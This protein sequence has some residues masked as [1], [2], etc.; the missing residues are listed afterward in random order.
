MVE[1]VVNTACVTA[2]GSSLVAALERT[3]VTAEPF[4]KPVI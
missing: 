2:G 4:P 1:P 3:T